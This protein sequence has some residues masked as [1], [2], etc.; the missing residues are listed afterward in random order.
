[1]AELKTSPSRINDSTA[2]SA[3]DDAL[4]QVEGAIADIFGIPKNTP[5]TGAIFGGING[6]GKIIGD[7]LTP[8]RVPSIYNTSALESS[9]AA[10]EFVDATEDVG[11]RLVPIQG[12]LKVYKRD[13]ATENSGEFIQDL[14]IPRLITNLDDV[15]I[16]DLSA[17]S[18]KLLAIDSNSPYH[19]IAV[20]PSSGGG[21]TTFIA[22]ND[23]PISYNGTVTGMVPT[24]VVDDPGP[25]VVAH[26]EFSAQA[27]GGQNYFVDLLDT[28]DDYDGK[29]QA[30]VC[31]ADDELGLVASFY[32]WAQSRKFDAVQSLA[33]NVTSMPIDFGVAGS[34]QFPAN[35]N[36]IQN[37]YIVLPQE[38]DRDC[39]YMIQYQVLLQKVSIEMN[40]VGIY[41]LAVD[42]GYIHFRHENILAY[43]PT[44]NTAI[45]TPPVSMNGSFIVRIP[46]GSLAASRRTLQIHIGRVGYNDNGY[47]WTFISGTS[48]DQVIRFKQTALSVCRIN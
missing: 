39:V 2:I 4:S 8:A 20:D 28:F 11:F 24:V 1:M 10:M 15:D 21:A 6:S 48:T 31:V 27:S 23:T 42:A 22:L 19:I 9:S 12:G 30:S 44:N 26:L 3:V 47:G 18:G 40:T 41:P 34:L 33:Y 16:A 35:N 7:G 46:K 17:V 14:G 32:S 45:D 43:R 25:P 29:A 13:P 36:I 37:T 5:I 38:L